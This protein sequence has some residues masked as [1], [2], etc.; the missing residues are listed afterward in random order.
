ML[1]GP[2]D[3]TTPEI[4]ATKSV[5][6]RIA[7]YSG[8]WKI[9]ETGWA[10]TY[11]REEGLV[12]QISG[13]TSMSEKTFVFNGS[14]LNETQEGYVPAENYNEATV[15][16]DFGRTEVENDKSSPAS[17]TGFEKITDSG[18]SW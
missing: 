11:K 4:A 6:R 10:W 16:N 8:K 5:T 9:E 1:F 18:V 2:E 15:T 3:A 13:V 17:T 7:L 14:K 12:R